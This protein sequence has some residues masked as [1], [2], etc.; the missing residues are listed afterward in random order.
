MPT[1]LQYTNTTD[2]TIKYN[3]MNVSHMRCHALH[4]FVLLYII[5]NILFV[6]T[7]RYLGIAVF[8]ETYNNSTTLKIRHTRNIR[9]SRGSSIKKVTYLGGGGGG[10]SSNFVTE[11]YY[12]NYNKNN[13]K[14]LNRSNFNFFLYKNFFKMCCEKLRKI[15]RKG[16]DMEGVW[17]LWK[18]DTWFLDDP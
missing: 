1:F 16:V 5:S 9:G 6:H 15:W 11:N 12:F 14:I 10:L 2:L 17:N 4:K 18:S 7:V 8:D 13:T 3:G